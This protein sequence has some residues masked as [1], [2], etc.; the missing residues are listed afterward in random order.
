MSPTVTALKQ[1]MTFYTASFCPARVGQVHPEPPVPT[2]LRSL[3]ARPPADQFSRPVLPYPTNE[4]A[5]RRK[6]WKSDREPSLLLK[7]TQLVLVTICFGRMALTSPMSN[8]LA[9]MQLV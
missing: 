6:A 8:V 3:F 9:K 2:H 7:E 4:P 1:E 5:R